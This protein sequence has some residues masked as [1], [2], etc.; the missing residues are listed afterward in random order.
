MKNSF[1]LSSPFFQKGKLENICGDQQKEA[2]SVIQNQFGMEDVIYCQDSI[3]ARYLKAAH[4]DATKFCLQKKSQGDMHL[5]IVEMSYHLRAYFKNTIARL[6]SQIPL[7][8]QHYVL[9]GSATQLHTQM[10]LL[11]QDKQNLDRMLQEKQDLS[12]ERKSLKDRIDRL[13][14]A[15]RRLARFPN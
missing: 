10:I 5:S 6:A 7:I 12:T 15:Q 3:Y 8:I 1:K 2:E 14:K 4:E 13:E 11:I 9:R